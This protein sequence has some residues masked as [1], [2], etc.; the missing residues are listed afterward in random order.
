MKNQL[1]SKYHII[2]LL[3]FMAIAFHGVNG[4]DQPTPTEIDKIN[5]SDS[6]VFKIEL[7]DR[8]T[9]IG[10]IVK[11]EMDFIEVKTE[12]LGVIVVKKNKI[13]EIGVFEETDQES[14]G[15]KP[16][17]RFQRM[18]GGNQYLLSNSAFNLEKGEGN[19]RFTELFFISGGYGITK[20][21]SVSAGF[22]FVPSEPFSEQ[23]FYVMPKA[24]FEVLPWIN[25]SAQLMPIFLA[26]DQTTLY[27]FTSTFGSLDRN[28]SLGYTGF[29][30]EPGAGLLNLSGIYRFNQWFAVISNNLIAVG[31]EVEEE[32]SNTV[33]G[34]GA[35]AMGKKNSFDFGLIFLPE[36]GGDL[37][38]PYIN[39]TLRF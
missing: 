27:G 25:V 29:F 37:P 21:L 24:S 26:E 11:H 14:N 32:F 23:L 7:V 2:T 12:N 35:R 33:Y 4:Q 10:K 34:I 6:L 1:S 36:N 15:Y 18:V 3:A 28:V 17:A 19:L 9:I 8:T 31:N 16:G 30:E 20:F 13:V 22:S 38:L 5:L 39:Y